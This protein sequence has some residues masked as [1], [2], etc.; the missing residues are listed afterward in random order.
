MKRGKEAAPAMSPRSG[1]PLQNQE[2]LQGALNK[3]LV[4]ERLEKP[5]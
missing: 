5:V 1:A 4:T 2:I 3:F